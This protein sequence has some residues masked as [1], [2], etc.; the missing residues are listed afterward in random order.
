MVA[1]IGSGPSPEGARCA[2]RLGRYDDASTLDDGS[3]PSVTASIE[4]MGTALA[5]LETPSDAVI[6]LSEER[7]SLAE[8]LR[9]VSGAP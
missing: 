1:S 5:T 6:L 2:R 7:R 8:P 9:A 3:D 4:W